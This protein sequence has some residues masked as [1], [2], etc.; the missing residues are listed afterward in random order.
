[1]ASKMIENRVAGIVGR[2]GTGKTWRL[3][4]MFCAETRSLLYQPVR[5][6]AESDRCATVIDDGNQD[7]VFDMLQQDS[8][9]IVY[10]PPDSDFVR[11]GQRLM[12]T[13]LVPIMKMCYEV[14]NMTLYLDEAHLLCNQ[15]TI[16]P[17]VER[18]IFLARNTQLNVVW[19]AQSMEV[20]RDIRR[21]TDIFYFMRMTEPG[22][23]E[24]VAER[25]G[26]IAADRVANL[27]CVR[28]E[29]ER[30]VPGECFVW[31]SMAL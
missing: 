18:I 16:D 26:D 30:I 24:K 1:M 13:S 9:R 19:V 12:Y 5:R 10:K 14:G 3:S 11:K 28:Q 4:R 15:Q 7:E 2:K 20:H 23:L 31:D 6:N 17:E 27:R 21:N 29:G 8:F 25:C 22:D